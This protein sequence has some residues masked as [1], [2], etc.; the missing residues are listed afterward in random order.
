MKRLIPIACVVVA[1]A[2]PLVEPLELLN[3][4]IRTLAPTRAVSRDTFGTILSMRHLPNG[5]VLVNDGTK[6]RVVHLDSM[7][8]NPVVVLDSTSGAANAYGPRPAPFIPYLG[9]TV[10]FADVA[11]QVLLVIDPAGKVARTIAPPNPRDLLP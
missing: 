4:P 5:R 9:D 7:L 11:A 8:A 1:A 6:R 10:L 3:I 2:T